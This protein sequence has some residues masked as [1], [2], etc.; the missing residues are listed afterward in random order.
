MKRAGQGITQLD[1]AIHNFPNLMPENIDLTAFMDEETIHRV[2]DARQYRQ[3]LYEML[4][5]KGDAGF[6]T[7][8]IKADFFRF[9]EAE[10]TVWAGYKGHGKSL[11][12]SQVLLNMMTN[13]GA[14]V[15]I[16]SPEF[17]PHQVLHRLIW[18]G[19][20]GHYSVQEMDEWLSVLSKIMWLYDLQGSLKPND[21]PALC[22]YA[23]EKLGVNH[24]LIDSLMKCG[25]PPD[26]LSGQKR[27]VDSIQ[28]IA[29][30]T[31]VHIHL[32]AH[33]RKGKDDHSAGGIHDIKG[34]SEIGDM[35]EN[36]L[37]VWR[38]KPKEQQKDNYEKAQEPDALFKVEAQRNGSGEIGQVPLLYNKHS[39]IYSE[40][41][42]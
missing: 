10:M 4:A 6:K 32:V 1:A 5:Q 7:P 13:Y 24:I 33:A 3:R 30:R 28:Q 37:V 11:L 40:M 41:G 25:I 42:E 23:A 20:E 22:R 15:F 21:V 19:V 2:K 16:I 14:K 38:N 17:Q 18:Q 35:A 12:L 8:W 9:R 34:T 26:D 39:M 36:V 27:F 31:G 29:H